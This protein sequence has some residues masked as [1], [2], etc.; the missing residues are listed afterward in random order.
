M[1]EYNYNR[2]TKMWDIKVN[3][4]LT[5][6]VY[7]VAWDEPVP[8]AGLSPISNFMDIDT[9]V[10]D[11]VAWKFIDLHKLTN[12]EIYKDLD[13]SASRKAGEEY[14]LTEG[15]YESGRS[16]RWDRKFTHELTIKQLTKVLRE[17]VIKSKVFD[18]EEAQYKIDSEESRQYQNDLDV[19]NTLVK[20]IYVAYQ[21][22][23]ILPKALKEMQSHVDSI[24]KDIGRGDLAYLSD[25][26]GCSPTALSGDILGIEFIKSKFH[27]NGF[28]YK[29]F[30]ENFIKSFSKLADETSIDMIK[31]GL[32]SDLRHIFELADEKYEEGRNRFTCLNQVNIEDFLEFDIDAFHQYMIEYQT[33]FGVIY[34]DSN[35]MVNKY[36]MHGV[37]LSEPRKWN[38]VKHVNRCLDVT[39]YKAYDI[40]KFFHEWNLLENMELS[41]D[42]EIS[43]NNYRGGWVAG[44]RYDSFIKASELV[45]ALRPI[46]DSD[47]AS[48]RLDDYDI[49]WRA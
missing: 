37:E 11:D 18:D 45:K 2:E 17:K 39:G 29:N 13:W 1:I 48:S 14:L 44:C 5:L 47:V 40:E 41:L 20:P 42:A 26:I 32:P 24:N 7:K 27:K 28:I 36:K 33:R 15:F 43:Y 35:A 23:S 6:S 30:C 49:K 3:P 22:S 46:I 19:R 12:P 31:L 25:C 8:K 4:K 21:F 10:K 9:N 38:V 34:Q 16:K